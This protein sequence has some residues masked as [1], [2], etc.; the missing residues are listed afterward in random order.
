MRLREPK[1]RQPK[2]RHRATL[3]SSQRAHII[4]TQRYASSPAR[5]SPGESRAPYR[6]WL[7]LAHNPGLEGTEANLPE[8]QL[9]V[10]RGGLVLLRLI[11]ESD[12]RLAW[13]RR[14]GM[15]HDGCVAMRRPDCPCVGWLLTSSERSRRAEDTRCGC[16]KDCAR[17]LRSGVFARFPRWILPG[18]TSST[19]A[20]PHARFAMRSDPPAP[21]RTPMPDFD[22]T[23]RRLGDRE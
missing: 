2:H 8:E 12:S 20:T 10:Q 19:T 9:A 21:S 23:R 11:A 18:D 22:M 6:P 3:A 5:G 15:R 17:A 7:Q 14:E 13:T 16:G 1:H 4:S